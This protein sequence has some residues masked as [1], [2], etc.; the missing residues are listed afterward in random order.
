[1]WHGCVDI[2]LGPHPDVAVYAKDSDD[3]IGTD[4]DGRL[5]SFEVKDNSD[6]INDRSQ[7]IAET[8]VFAFLQKKNNP[9]F[10]NYLIPTVAVSK[11]D[12]LFHFYDPEHDIL[13][14]SPSFSIFGYNGQLY[15]PTVLALWFTLNY[16]TFCTGI[17]RGMK[18]RN[19][20]ADFLSR[21][22]DEIKTI[23]KKYLHFR[24][25]EIGS[26]SLTYYMPKAHAGWELDKT[27]PYKSSVLKCS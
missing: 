19:F 10:E 1:M 17:T 3:A 12:V 16:K 24:D 26:V 5:S 20:T 7:I 22:N 13:L 25:C 2:L 6:L 11:K 9:A 23:Y 15:F 14:E 27:E 18:E 8:I 21:V 4:V